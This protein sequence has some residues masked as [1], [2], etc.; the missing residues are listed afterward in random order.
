MERGKQFWTIGAVCILVLALGPAA[1]AQYGGG[2]GEPNDPYL[3]YTPQQMNA[4][5][6]DPNDWDK[7]FKL[8]A[9]I[10]LSEFV[11]DRAPIAPDVDDAT[12]FQGMPF[13]GVFDGNE[14]TVSHL[15]IEG[16]GHLGLFGKL[17]SEARVSNLTM[18]AVDVNGTGD[19]VAALA[20]INEGRIENCHST[21]VI[22]GCVYV[23]GLVGYDSRGSISS[24]SSTSTIMAA[25]NVG[26]LVGR[27]Y[28]DELLTC[29]SS[30]SVTGGDNAGGLAGV[31]WEGALLECYSTARV[32]GNDNVGGLVGYGVLNSVS[33]CYSTGEVTGHDDIGGL[34]G[35]NRGSVANCYSTG[36]VAGSSCVGGLIGQTDYASVSNCY[37]TGSVTGSHEVGG[38]VGDEYRENVV[39]S[40]WDVETS[41]WARSAAGTGLRTSEMQTAATF[42]AAGWDLVEETDNGAED[43]W[44][45]PEGDYPHLAWELEAHPSCPVSVIELSARNF[46]GTIAEGVVLVDFY[47]TWCSYCVMQAPILEEVAAEVQG[48]A[49]VAKLDVDMARSVAQAYGVTA[50]PTLILFRDGEVVERFVGLTEAEELVAAIERA[51]AD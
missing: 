8:M 51:V 31:N 14:C 25:D 33:R 13:E 3:I 29:H 27:S 38:L 39:S 4:I 26:G 47:A 1:P 34:V 7:H 30:G 41:G 44:Y 12:R 40:F 49:V 42:L 2:T 11:Y 36:M 24:S 16:S 17:S 48:Q 15:T 22:S 19:Y 21:G 28:E 43:I 10:D 9:D 5:G 32:S 20:G 37:S 46:D 6:A 23:G 50:I 45:L 35:C 18:E